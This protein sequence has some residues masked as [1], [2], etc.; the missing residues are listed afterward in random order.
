MI[1]AERAG[2]REAE[3]IAARAQAVNAHSDALIARLRLEIEKLKRDIHGSRS[4]RKARLLEQMELQLEEL[5]A[6]ASHDELAAEMAARSSTT[7]KAFERKRPSRKP[8]PE[9][10]PRERVVIAAP[11]TCPCCGSGK[12]AKLGEDITETLE[13][14]PRQ[15]KVIQTVREKFTCRECEKITQPPA[16]FHV[17]PRGF[18]GPN[19]LAMILFEKFGQ[20]QPLNRQSERYA[21]E[22][23][24]LSLST[25]ADQVGACAA[26]LKPVH[27]LIEAHVLS[28]DRLHG[29]DTTVPILA[30]GK[31]D[32]GRIWTYVRDD[33]PFCGSSPPAALYYAS[34]DRRQEHPERHLK[35]FAGILQADAYGGYNPL[36]KVDRDLGP[37]TQ[38][39]CWAH[40]RRKFFG[41]ADIATNAKRGKNATPIS[42]VALD[43]VK[44]IDA[45]FDIE[46]DINGLSA[47]ERL[48]RRQQESR[49]LVDELENWMRIERSKLSRSSPV[50]EPIDY[51]LKRWEGFT[52]FLGDGRICLTNNAAERALRGF[53]LGRKSWLFAG[54]DRGADRAAFMATLIMTAKLNDIDPQAWLADVLARIAD[55]P[56]T[57]LAELLP[58]HWKPETAIIASAA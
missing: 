39:L 28:A 38:A 36:F 15:W 29:D 1:L 53:A 47:N 34:R 22:G 57:K 37:L 45:L 10:L 2:R 25:L 20:H 40:S 35:S 24:D 12:L 42:P 46:R 32:T 21:R 16:P 27:A 54:S 4:E 6:D 51:M 5:E 8:F 49:P 52:T 41:L 30:K 17:T 19:L 7:V 23:I 14:I 44:R 56:V 55:M 31:T 58:W 18:A 11:H 13:V 9:H 33:R 48:Q 3:A 26:A 50:T 43:A